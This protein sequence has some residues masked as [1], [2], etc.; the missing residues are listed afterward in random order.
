MSDETPRD[1]FENA[2]HLDAHSL[3]GLAHPLRMHILDLLQAHGPATGK[4]LA[5][6]L[7]ISSASASY[8]LRRLEAHGFI[9]ED[10]ELGTSR[11]RWWRA[12]HRGFRFPEHLDT[13][14]PELST[15]V[16]TALAA[17]WGRDLAAAVEGWAAQPEGWREAQVMAGRS[18]HLT[19]EQ[20]EGL[21]R[22]VR[23]LLDR[24]ACEDP[25]PGTRPVHVR[26]AAFPDPGGR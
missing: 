17:S 8:H 4:A 19:L 15:A 1:P 6:R 20:L 14:E 7:E 3:R 5:E 24:Y 21:R 23:A 12:S 25:A 11:E 22:E 2:K 10:P 9:H 16:R 13:D 18:A 26:F